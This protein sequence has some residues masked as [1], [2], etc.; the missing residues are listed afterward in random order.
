MMLVCQYSIF[1]SVNIA[2]SSLKSFHLFQE[3]RREEEE[4][5]A[6]LNMQFAQESAHAKLARDLCN[7]VKSNLLLKL[8]FSKTDGSVIPLNKLW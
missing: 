2:W 6:Q 8:S 7:E 1:L 3:K 4:A 5:E